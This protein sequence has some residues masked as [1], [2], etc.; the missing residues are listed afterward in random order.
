MPDEIP[1]MTPDE[2]RALNT[3]DFEL[4]YSTVLTEARRRNTLA[5]SVRQIA[6]I[7]SNY[8]DARDGEQ[9]N[10]LVTHDPS[11]WPAWVQPTGAHDSYPPDR[12]V[13]FKDKLWRNDLGVSNPYEPGTS[14]ARWVD[15]TDEIIDQ[16]PPADPEPVPLWEPNTSYEKNQAVFYNGTIYYC[17]Q[18][19]VS[20]PGLEPQVVPALWTTITPST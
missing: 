11:K 2:L 13:Q 6:E 16:A 20:L 9:P 10:P 15:V 18:P 19:H 7:Q 17:V 14:N 4:L 12:I 1:V 3:E 5:Q 8:L